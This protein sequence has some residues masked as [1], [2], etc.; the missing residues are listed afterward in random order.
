MEHKFIA[1]K[2]S[3][4]ISQKNNATAE[5]VFPLLCP[6]READWIDGWQY[7]MIYSD[8]G[9]VEKGCVFSTPNPDGTDSVW[10]ITEFDSKAWH[11]E[12]VRITAGEMVVKISINLSNNSDATTHTKI[13]YEYTSL[14]EKSNHWLVHDLDKYFTE[15][16]SYW[17][18][19]I[20][21]YLKTGKKLEKK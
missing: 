13:T 20:N 16:M 11:I 14:S 17:E 21:Y 15:M 3:K 18:K 1:K 10:Y 9:L 19:A 5:K 7:K 2:V 12:F 8:S 6:V 4:S